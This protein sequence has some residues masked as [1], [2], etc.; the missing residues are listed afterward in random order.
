MGEFEETG[1]TDAMRGRINEKYGVDIDA[2]IRKEANRR[3]Q[4]EQTAIDEYIDELTLALTVERLRP[5]TTLISPVV[6][7]NPLAVP[8]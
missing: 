3:T 1:A 7:R 8:S 2:A 4:G 5:T 6:S